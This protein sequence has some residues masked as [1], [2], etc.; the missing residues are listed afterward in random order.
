MSIINIE[1]LMPVIKKTKIEELTELV[2]YHCTQ[3]PTISQYYQLR[4]NRLI[5]IIGC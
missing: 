2:A 4:S 5:I 1:K 3:R